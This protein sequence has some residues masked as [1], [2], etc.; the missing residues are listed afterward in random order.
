VY[1]GEEQNYLSGFT[2][3]KLWVNSC[4]LIQSP[5]LRRKAMYDIHG[6]SDRDRLRWL[7]TLCACIV[8]EKIGA[9]PTVKL[10]ALDLFRGMRGEQL[11]LLSCLLPFL[12]APRA[13]FP[14]LSRLH[15]RIRGKPI[16]PTGPPGPAFDP[17]RL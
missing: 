3:Y 5:L 11:L 4:Q 2:W 6:V 17:L 1:R 14:F 16:A 7:R 15:K 8:E 9:I 13:V 10:S 12:F